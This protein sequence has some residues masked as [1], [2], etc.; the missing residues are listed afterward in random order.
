MSRPALGGTAGDRPRPGDLVVARN[1]KWDG[2]AHWVVPG[3]QLGEDDHGWWIYQGRGEFISRPGAA[4]HT[5]S[6]AVLLVPRDGAYASTFYDDDNPGEFRVYVDLAWDL[7]W[8]RIRNAPPGGTG[9]VEFHM[10]DMDLDVIRSS[11]SGVFVDDEDEFEEHRASMDYPGWL[12]DAVREETTRLL[13]AVQDGS[14]PFGGIADE[15]LARGR[16]SHRKDH[17]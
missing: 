16:K 2:G 17:P 15:W 6:D 13:A 4:L 5:L 7:A 9:A 3:V 8:R 12:V 14:G 1:R 11:E 10:V